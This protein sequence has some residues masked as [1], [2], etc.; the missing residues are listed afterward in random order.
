M[1]GSLLY[2]LSQIWVC[3][4]DHIACETVTDSAYV[5]LF[6]FF[7]SLCVSICKCTLMCVPQ[8]FRGASVYGIILMRMSQGT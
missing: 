5:C 8:V 3:L 4:H 2:V 1:S 7:V 6:S